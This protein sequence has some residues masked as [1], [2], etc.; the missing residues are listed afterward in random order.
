MEHVPEHGETH[1][2]L[3]VITISARDVSRSIEDVEQYDSYITENDLG[4]GLDMN[5]GELQR[6]ESRLDA[7]L[8]LWQ[9]GLTGEKI[10][11]ASRLTECLKNQETG[12]TRNK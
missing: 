8:S 2:L 10:N 12:Q 9:E 4:E 5:G 3:L 6:T 7:L 11:V 1:P